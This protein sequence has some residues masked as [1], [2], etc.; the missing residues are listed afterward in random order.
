[1]SATHEFEYKSRTVSITVA[2]TSNGKQIG[3]FTIPGTEP[4]VRGTGAARDTAEA[5]LQSAEAKA[6][7]L[8]DGL[9]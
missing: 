3:S 5:A 6:R 7:E 4:L 8:I 1:M 9:S 2:M